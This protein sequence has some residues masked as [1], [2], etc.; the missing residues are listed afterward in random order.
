M[1]KEDLEAQVIE[2][3]LRV[4]PEA[5]VTSMDPAKSFRDQFEIDS[6]DYLSFVL[7]LEKILSIKIPEMDYPKLSSLNGCLIYLELHLPN[8]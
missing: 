5:D 8:L 1:K 3:F 2:I 7:E 4:V 6:V